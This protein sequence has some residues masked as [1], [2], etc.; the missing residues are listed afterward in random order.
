MFSEVQ[1]PL[2]V[3]T[4]LD[5]A[6]V[7]RSGIVIASPD[8]VGDLGPQPPAL[9]LALL[10]D[11]LDRDLSLGDGGVGKDFFRLVNLADPGPGSLVS[12][13]RLA[14]VGQGGLVR[15]SLARDPTCSTTGSVNG[16]SSARNQMSET[17]SQRES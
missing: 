15:V 1:S 9:P 8:P 10:L 11:R 17:G 7:P 5:P 4:H 6:L 2:C 3:G 13:N 12:S 14:V 16:T